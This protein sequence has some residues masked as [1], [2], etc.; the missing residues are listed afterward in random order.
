MLGTFEI[1]E[2]GDPAQA[3]RRR[4]R[5]HDL[6]GDRQA[7][8]GD[9]ALAEA[10]ERRG[11]ARHVTASRL[12][13]V[14]RGR[15]LCPP[16]NVVGSPDQHG[17]SHRDPAARPPARSRAAQHRLCARDA[18]SRP[19]RWSGWSVNLVQDPTE[20]FNILLIGLTNGSVYG[21]IALGYTLVY[22]ILQLINFAHG[23]VFALGGLVASTMILTVLDL[24]TADSRGRD[25]PRHRGDA[26]IAIG[27]LGQSSTRRSSS[28]PTAGCATRRGSR[29]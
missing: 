11:R 25:R 17:R 16:S 3:R 27:L 1:N 19:R 5:L 24:S 9:D 13:Q 10:G 4:R 15:A 20:F 28:S 29:R 2:N 26:R 23:D 18:L 22:G 12:P 14:V 6:Q 21:L 8:D 7:R